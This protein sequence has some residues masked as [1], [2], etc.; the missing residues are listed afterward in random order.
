MCFSPFTYSFK[1]FKETYYLINV[2][3]ENAQN[4]ICTIENATATNGML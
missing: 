2:V 1:G 4:D 3:S